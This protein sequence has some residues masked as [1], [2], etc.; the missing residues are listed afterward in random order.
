MNG[1]V[2]GFNSI[3]YIVS[4]QCFLYRVGQCG[5]LCVFIISSSCFKVNLG[6]N[7]FKFFEFLKINLKKKYKVYKCFQSYQ[8]VILFYFVLG[9]K[10]VKSV[11][12]CLCLGMCFCLCVCVY[13]LFYQFQVFRSQQFFVMQDWSSV[14]FD[15]QFY[16]CSFRVVVFVFVFYS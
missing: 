14:S 5:W 8:L 9:K 1:F 12:E 6:R 7:S 15:R 2:I 13:Y 10:D 3:F 11:Y 16:V 4:Y